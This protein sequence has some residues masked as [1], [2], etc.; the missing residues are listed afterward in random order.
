M[1]VI[2]NLMV[3]IGADARGYVGA[4]KNAR[5]VTKQASENIGKN[6][7]S[8][9]QAVAN[10]F[11][12]SQMSMK[13]YLSL[14]D[15]FSQKYT[16]ATQNKERL[17]DKLGQMKNVYALVKDATAGLD[18]SKSFEETRTEAE[19]TLTEIESKRRKMEA[20]LAELSS[21]SK[22]RN[23]PKAAKIQK[24][25]EAL[26]N[27]SGY[28]VRQLMRLDEVERKL[29]SKNIGYASAAGLKQLESSIA[30][31]ETELKTMSA[32][33][34]ES[35]QKLA[36]LGTP[37]QLI[38]RNIGSAIKSIGTAA[39]SVVSGG[40]KRL[41]TGL[42]NLGKS[43]IRGITSL[44]G[45][46]RQIGRSASGSCGGLSRMVAS[47]R[48]IGFASLGMRVAGGMFGRLRSII[49]SYIQQN[50]ALNASV[51]TM[52]NQ[53]GEALLPAINMV[54]TA[55]QSLMPIVTALSAGISSVMQ[56]LFGKVVKTTS[57]IKEAGGAASKSLEL[58]GFDQITK[59]NEDSGRGGGTGSS[60]NAGIAATQSALVDK[61][62]GWVQKLK[63]AFV[64]GDWNQVGTVL[65]DG[66]KSVL[67]KANDIVVN[68]DWLKIGQSIRSFLVGIDWNGILSSLA[69]GL[70]AIVGGLAAMIWGMIGPAW[71]NVVKWWK[72]NAYKDGEFTMKGLLSG[73]GK[74]LANIGNWIKEN[75]FDPFING[76]RKAFKIN[77]PSVVM[78]EH[79]GFLIG[80][81]L[82]GITAA[83]ERIKAF[84]GTALPNLSGTVSEA[85]SRLKT[86]VSNIWK[87]GI[88]PAVKGPVNS[89]ISCIN[90]MVSGVVSGINSLIKALNRLSFEV[91]DWVPEIGGKTFGFSLKTISAPQIPMLAR[92]GIVNGA[93]AII[94]GEQG[95]EAIVPLE[96]NTEWKKQIADIIREG[97][98]QGG[99][100]GG[101]AVIQIFLGHR[102]VTEFFIR[103]INQITR[104]NG[105]CPIYV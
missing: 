92:G 86:S 32:I 39:G 35:K 43:A 93:T 80:G 27:K 85:F 6:T 22:G 18:L 69:E 102:K 46:L 76:F 77:S 89:I 83:W 99:G 78:E 104:E 96:H 74:V 38:R 44:P 12:G 60:G 16:D 31:T 4:I 62:V 63:A 30:S 68:T 105:V 94:A 21:T 103:D 25:L 33:A 54:M 67:A 7:T 9:K 49:S 1:G 53:M 47:I 3:R 37:G 13:E 42:L 23:S 64:A 81:L 82:N 101:S 91:P 24:E 41:G 17:K 29:G 50:E 55:M 57:A 11:A 51:Q 71:G 84:F 75:I 90:G 8:I 2:K 15:S 45:R 79:G 66:I 28:V 52:K 88:V 40:V 70:G 5:S 87:N 59:A 48:N 73:I 34:T 20:D 100:P 19:K 56:A 61:L 65:S 58:Y 14:V 36:A 10:G 72:E 26:A 98:A 97:Q 95:K